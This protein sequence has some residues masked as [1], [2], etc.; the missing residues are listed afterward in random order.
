MKIENGFSNRIS[1]AR[2]AANLTQSQLADAVGVV[3]RQIAAYEAGDSK[4]RDKV[5]T[6]L[7]AALGTSREWLA[8]GI[9]DEPDISGIRKS[10]TTYEMPVM[11]YFDYDITDLLKDNS[12]S[13]VSN[14]TILAP[15]KASADSIAIK[16]KGDSMESMSGVS[17][18]DGVIVVFDPSLNPQNGDIAFIFNDKS[19]VQLCRQIIKDQD[20]WYLRPFNAKYPTEPYDSEHMHVMGIAIH[21]EY[22]LL[23]SRDSLITNITI[24]SDEKSEI[25]SE[26][27]NIKSKLDILISRK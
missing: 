21:L 6:N 5:L 10:V 2:M 18:P 27:S 7:A 13:G 12:I 24:K 22:D 16:M 14:T 20:K 1:L 8:K 25:I 19:G 15:P 23:S 3:R 17:L 26:L 9:G 11:E 4:P